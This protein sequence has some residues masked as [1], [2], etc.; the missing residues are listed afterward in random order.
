MPISKVISR[1][2]SGNFAKQPQ[3]IR[4]IEDRIHAWPPGLELS[5]RNPSQPISG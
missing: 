1:I 4:Q 3:G 5:G 2:S